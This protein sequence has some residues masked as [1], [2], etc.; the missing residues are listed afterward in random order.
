MA[1]IAS[2]KSIG[3]LRIVALLVERVDVR[4]DGVEI[5]LR[6]SGLVRDVAGSPIAAA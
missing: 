1:R 6:P 4:V 3:L 5:R 2:R